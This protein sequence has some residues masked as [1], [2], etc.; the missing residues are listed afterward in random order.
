MDRSFYNIDVTVNLPNNEEDTF[1]VSNCTLDHA[2]SVAS[3]AHPNWE[4]M[5]FVVTNGPLSE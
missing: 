5:I 3:K 1:V 4:S 2:A